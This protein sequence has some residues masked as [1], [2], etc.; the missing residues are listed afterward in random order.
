MQAPAYKNDTGLPSVTDIFE[1][2]VDSR[3]FTPESRDR[4]SIVHHAVAAHLKGLWMPKLAA[5][6]V[7]YVDSAKRWIDDKVAD[8]IL[9]EERLISEKYGFTGALD[10]VCKFKKGGIGY[11]DWKTSEQH[12]DVWQFKSYAYK[13]LF[14]SNNPVEIDY[15]A[16]VRLRKEEGKKALTNVYKDDK[17]DRKIFISML[18]I[19]NT[20]FR[21]KKK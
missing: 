15:R 2:V 10:L 8:V 17:Y 9:V 13:V 7:P 18:N 19:Y 6:L 4:G 14:E 12:Y 11:I 3:W 1:S 21:G 20:F 5:P 16:S